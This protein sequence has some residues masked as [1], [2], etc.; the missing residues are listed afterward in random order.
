M[1]LVIKRITFI[2]ADFKVLQ[3]TLCARSMEHEKCIR[4]YPS[5]RL[6]LVQ[7]GRPVF[8]DPHN[9]SR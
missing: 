1:K 2:I 9:Y 4:L 6:I 7:L 5:L 3:V 8:L